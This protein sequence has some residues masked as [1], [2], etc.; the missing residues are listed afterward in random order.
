MIKVIANLNKKE[1]NVSFAIPSKKNLFC[2]VFNCSDYST[3]LSSTSVKKAKFFNIFEDKYCVYFDH[4][5][6]M[7]LGLNA[8]EY[9]IYA[10]PHN[11]Y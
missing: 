4:N 1:C 11:K 2:I 6:D 7:C 3:K 10:L 8:K 5:T 9:I